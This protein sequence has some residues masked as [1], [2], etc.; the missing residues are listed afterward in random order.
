M[1]QDQSTANT[2]PLA[3]RTLVQLNAQAHVL[4]TEVRSLQRSLAKVQREVSADRSAQ[5]VEANERL[6]LAALQ[7]QITADTATQDLDKLSRSC[8]RDPLTDTPNR[9]LMLDRLENALTMAQRRGTQVAILFLDLDHFKEI[10]DTLGHA[11]GDAVLQLVARR[12]ASAVRD[13]DA[14]SRHGGDEF[15]MLLMEVS[16]LEDAAVIAKKVLQ[17]IAE[18]STVL[19]HPL[20]LSASVGIALY[21]QDGMDASAL[22]ALADAA[23]YRSKR[24]GGGTFTFHTEDALDGEHNPSVA[25]AAQ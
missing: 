4:R 13:S 11:T 17:D 16:K 20:Q 7:A 6:V 21:P 25:P 23:M 8:Q 9:A 18:T 24:R 3:A 1:M 19:G 14:V 2:V 5:L 12:M 22:I 15:L 10:N